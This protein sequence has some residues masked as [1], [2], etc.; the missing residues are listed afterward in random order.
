MDGLL[1]TIFRGAGGWPRNLGVRFRD[2]VVLPQWVSRIRECGWPGRSAILRNRQLRSYAA[3]DG[4]DETMEQQV[5][6]LVGW[7]I[8]V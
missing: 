5:K 2:P 4:G 8:V 7:R 3:D 1:V 6:N